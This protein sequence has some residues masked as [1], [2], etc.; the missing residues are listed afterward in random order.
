MNI[1]SKIKTKLSNPG[2]RYTSKYKSKYISISKLKLLL[3]YPLVS[4]ILITAT[5]TPLTLL[6]SHPAKA[7]TLPAYNYTKTFD[8]SASGADASGYSIVTD[9]SGNVYVT[10]YF[11]GTVVF[12]GIGGSDSQTSANGSSFLTKYNPNGSYGYTKIFESVEA[13]AKTMREAC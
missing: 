11:Q 13:A 10:G 5:L 9:N 8:T 7:Q 12:D 1:V 4:F 3:S 2:F 6:P